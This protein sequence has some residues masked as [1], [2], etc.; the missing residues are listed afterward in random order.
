MATMSPIATLTDFIDSIKEKL[1]DGEYIEGMNMCK[2]VFDKKERETPLKLYRMTY[3]RP[4]M[5]MDEHCDDEDCD[6]MKYCLSFERTT[7]LVQL[8]DRGAARIRETNLF[9]GDK[10]EMSAFVDVDV[11]HSFPNEF[12]ENMEWYEFP[13]I[14][15]ELADPPAIEPEPE[16]DTEVTVRDV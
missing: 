4:Y 15:L 5:F 2:K 16:S 9:L 13:V 14:T 8:T 7:S 11:F 3:L 10:E 12:D 6:D 1:T